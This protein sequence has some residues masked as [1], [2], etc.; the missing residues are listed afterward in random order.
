M[1]DLKNR[2]PL[3]LQFF[4]EGGLEGEGEEGNQESKA[5]SQEEVLQLIQSEADKRVTE[6]LKKQQKKYEKEL[7]KQKSLVGLDEEARGKAEQEQTIAE[8]QE[9]LGQYQLA[10]TKAEI[11]KV[12]STRGLDANLVDFVVTS[13]DQDE[14]LEK[15]GTL[16]KIFKTMVKKEVD[17]RLKSNTP[18]STLGLGG[19]ITKDQFNK[20]TLAEQSELY[21]NNKELYTQLTRL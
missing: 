10:T 7:N 14:C 17:S 18:K 13:T 5:Y 21:T 12:L 6:A 19:E 8:L 3:N 15:I 11:A 2:F 4:A 1:S 16:D 20:M 9:Q